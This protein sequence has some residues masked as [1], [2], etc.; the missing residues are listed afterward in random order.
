MIFAIQKINLL[1]T[2]CIVGIVIFISTYPIIGVMQFFRTFATNDK[3][4]LI[5][6]IALPLFTAAISFS[7][8]L[9]ACFTYNI[10]AKILG[11]ITIEIKECEK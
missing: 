2:S 6:L 8:S 1:K 4:P 9:I 10:V 3:F 7:F 5:V 11:G